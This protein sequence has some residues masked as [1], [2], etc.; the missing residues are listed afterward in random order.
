M[1][2]GQSWSQKLKFSKLTEISYR[3]IFFQNSFHLYFQGKFGSKI[4]G[5]S[6]WL[7]FRTGLHCYMLTTILM[8]FFK[9]LSV[10]FFG[11]SGP[12]I[13]CSPSRLKFDTRAHCYMVITVLM[14]NF[15]KF[16]LFINFGGKFYP[17][18]CCSSYLLKLSIDIRWNFEKTR[19]KEIFR[20]RK[21][22]KIRAFD[23]N[24]HIILIMYTNAKYQSIGT[25][26]DVGIKFP[27][28][29]MNEKTLKIQDKH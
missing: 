7:K 27:P 11:W 2:L 22:L 4:W 24:Q 3:G 23:Y 17:E 6:N 20:T 12:K 26:S 8:F 10:I 25:K 9:V 1:F 14:C 16:L 15:L 18:I 5:S 21:F 29:Y 28:I 13:K 19:W